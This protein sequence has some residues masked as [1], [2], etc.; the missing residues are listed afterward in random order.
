[1]RM[2]MRNVLMLRKSWLAIGDRLI[3]LLWSLL[4]HRSAHELR[5]MR[6]AIIHE[7]D[8]IDEEVLYSTAISDA[9]ELA[10]MLKPKVE[11]MAA[12]F[13]VELGKVWDELWQCSSESA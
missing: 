8:A 9:W 5:G 6:N 13:G 4:K 10:Q 2:V 3:L 12:A 1:M 11:A 7:C